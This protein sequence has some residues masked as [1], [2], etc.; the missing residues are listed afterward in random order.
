M[1]SAQQMNKNTVA[2]NYTTQC[3]TCFGLS[4]SHHPA[5]V[6]CTLYIMVCIALHKGIPHIL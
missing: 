5:Q 2:Q 4:V 1:N 6:K 3:A